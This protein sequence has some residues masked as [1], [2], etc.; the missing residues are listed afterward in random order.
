M[1]HLQTRS[2]E[3]SWLPVRVVDPAADAP[4]LFSSARDKRTFLYGLSLLLDILSLIGGYLC[5][6]ELRDERWLA[7]GGQSIV[8]IALPI[9]IMF[10]IAREAQD[11][12]L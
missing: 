3:G 4:G 2:S 8:F 9:F 1:K 6:L 5:A 7:A 11:A 12:E 10:E